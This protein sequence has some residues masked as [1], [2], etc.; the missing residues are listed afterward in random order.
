MK[1]ILCREF[2]PP[3]KLTFEEIPS[4]RAGKGQVVITTKASGVNFPDTLMIEGK[5]QFKPEFP[6][7]PGG[8]ISG[9]IKEVGEGVSHLKSGQAVFALTGWGGFAEEV[10]AD[11]S[12]TIPVP[13]GMTFVQAAAFTVA[14]GT[15]F[16]AL[17]DRARLKEGETLLVLG[18]A[19]G[20]GLT[21]V[22]LG[23]VMGARVIAAASSEDKLK[24]CREYGASET[25]NYATE[26]LRA[27]IKEITGGKGV[28][29][30]YDPVGGNF[31]EPALRSM[32]W[33]GRYL[34]IGFAAGKIPEIP[35][36][37]PLLKGCQIMGV[38]WGEFAQREM[39]KN[40]ANFMQMIQWLREGKINPY[41]H[42]TYSLEDAPKALNEIL[43]RKAK[44]KIVLT[45]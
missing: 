36:N 12:V 42:Q 19:G 35:L 10:V 22:E 39:N 24:L 37:L 26:D 3:D 15:S 44:G 38:F 31:A 23:A 5:Y 45:P 13:E 20:V 9:V 25:I 11:A 32:G 21:A 14:Y 28:D 2:G 6:F 29:V 7:S 1:A 8:E 43:N 30:V 41:I 16:H 4:P 34:V 27:R 18:A 33:K 40:M 17:K